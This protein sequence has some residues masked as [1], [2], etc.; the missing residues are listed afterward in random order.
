MPQPEQP[1]HQ[2]RGVIDALPISF[3][4]GRGRVRS[5][6]SAFTRGRGFIL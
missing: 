6:R 1:Q 5:G 4:P 3:R 2:P